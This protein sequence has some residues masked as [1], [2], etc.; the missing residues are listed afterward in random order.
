MSQANQGITRIIFQIQKIET[1][2]SVTPATKKERKKKK[3]K[4]KQ[5]RRNVT[6]C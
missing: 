1:L 3:E 2:L 4:T 5:H 6:E